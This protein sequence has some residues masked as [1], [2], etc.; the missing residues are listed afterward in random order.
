MEIF[1]V[2]GAVRDIILNYPSSE[3][4]WVVVG[5][6]PKQLLDQGFANVGKDF[7]VFLHPETKEEYAL[8]RKERKV[9]GGYTGFEFDTSLSVSLEEDLNRRDLTINAIAQSED[10][11]FIDPYNGIEDIESRTLRHVSPAFAEDPVRVLRLARF[12]ARYHHLGFSVASETIKLVH[13]MVDAGEL[14]HLVPERVW[15]EFE[16]ALGEQHPEIFISV[17]RECKA[18][19]VIMPELDSLFGVPQPEQHHPEVDTGVHSVMTLEQA[20]KLSPSPSVRFASLMHDLGKALTPR[21]Q[22]PK[23]YG[24]EKLGLKSLET[25]CRRLKAP[26]EFSELALIVMQYHTHCHRAFELR[27][28]TLLE[29]FK[30]CDAYRRTQRFADFLVCC[31]ADAQGRTGFENRNYPQANYLLSAF[32]I[33]NEVKASS[34]TKLG[35]K[36]AELGEAINNEREKLL[37]DAVIAIRNSEKTV[38]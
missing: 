6:T 2:G 7:P 36:G 20:R 24:H 17:L 13:T 5:G 38:S 18:L 32:N 31:K 33:A 22:W 19:K 15:K 27:A 30:K 12:A 3:K 23:H 4:D 11:Q 34:F 10:G 37:R 1:L 25:L 16:K 29:L 9:A 35:F 26:K 14:N 21:E 28:D 8:A